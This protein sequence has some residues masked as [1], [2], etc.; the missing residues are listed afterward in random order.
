MG[1]QTYPEQLSQRAAPVITGHVVRLMEGYSR[2]IKVGQPVLVAVLTAA[3]V[4]RLLGALVAS[5]LRFG[6]SSGGARR[7]FKELRKGPEFL[8]TPLRLR[9]RDNLLCEVEIHGHLPQ[10]ALEPHDHVQVTL[11]R[12]KDGLAP[13]VERIVNLT[14]GQLLTPR[15]PTLWSHLGPALVLQA[16]VGLTLIGLLCAWLFTRGG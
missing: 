12:Q 1:R 16:M 14:T 13:R 9:I 4:G 2:E 8:V 15:T 6:G 10:T 7:K 5:V 11:R 3:A